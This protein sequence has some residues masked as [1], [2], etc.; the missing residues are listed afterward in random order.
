M[1]ASNDGRRG[2]R[3]DG[4]GGNTGDREDARGSHEGR[5]LPQLPPGG[6]RGTALGR[7]AAQGS[8]AAR[9]LGQVPGGATPLDRDDASSD[10]QRYWQ[11]VKNHRALVLG[12]FAAVVTGVTIG[13]FLQDPVYRASGTIEVR[14]QGGDVLP[15]EAL[16][17][18][19]RVSDQHLQ[20]QYGVLRSPALARR[21]IAQLNLQEVEEFADAEMEGVVAHFLDNLTVAAIDD[22]RL[23]QVS[24]E[25]KDPELAAQVVN[26][27]FD[28]YMMLRA[29]AHQATVAKLGDQADSVRRQLTDSEQRLQAFV[30][31]NELFLAETSDQ[32]EG[33]LLDDRL[34]QLQGELTQAEAEHFAAQARY[35]EFARRGSVQALDSRVI[36]ELTVPLAEMEA[37]YAKLRATFTD[38]F[39]RVAQLKRQIQS[40]RSQVE[41]ERTR[42][43]AQI[44]GEY[45]AASARLQMLRESFAEQR[46][47]AER[48]GS[49]SGEYSV[50]KRDAEGHEELYALLR[51]KEK[52]ADVSA[53]LAMTEVGVIDAAVAPPSPVRPSPTK[54]IPLGL[55]AGLLLGLCAAFVREYTDSKVRRIE[56]LDGIEVPILALIP[57]ARSEV[58][59]I[60]TAATA[61]SAGVNGLRPRLP[62]FFGGESGT[63]V[64]I[65]SDDWRKSALA[66]GF[67]NLRTSVLFSAAAGTA[68]RSLLVT[69]V[70]A[71]EGKTM[72]SMNLAISLARLG[73]RVLLVDAD[74]RRPSVHRAFGVIDAHGLSESL[75]GE[76]DWRDVV[77]D[78]GVPNLA[79]IT[80]GAPA[81]A[82]AELL[83]SERMRAFVQEAQS[84]HD[85]VV[86]D[87]P[88]LLVNV[89]DARI[90]SSYADG[91]VMVVRGGV[92]PREVLRRLLGH[93]P[94]VVGVVLNDL[95][96]SHLP[97]YYQDYRAPVTDADLH[98]LA[99]HDAQTRVARE[100]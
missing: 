26:A 53:A 6:A 63:W 31:D 27:V 58:G 29:D 80:A 48:L 18:L 37:E 52:E 54:N 65:D 85:F 40:L 36:E 49:Q 50:L 81:D 45:R 12:V 74:L 34:R 3:R 64:R 90:L 20:T 33:S 89:A 84:E 8:A 79:V 4:S 92:T 71:G 87:S 70:Q 68:T 1:S 94:N 61:T 100:G 99:S 59:L 13:T 95:G 66:E 2:R 62:S 35:S 28:A 57:S 97:G 98:G 16:F 72:V 17:E 41:G 91:I 43:A 69:S 83:S 60:R 78:V 46:A 22:S 30:R 93:M 7:H 11:I 82:P 42:M 75:A 15:V 14:K 32:G 56:E 44:G 38:S 25:S 73:R 86:I 55:F 67:S 51:Q 10:L 5:P 77:K 24:F 9:V 76:E 96:S 23:I 19:A 39:P 47:L 21:V 88:A